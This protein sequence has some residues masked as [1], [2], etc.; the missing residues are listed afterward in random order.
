V[1]EASHG[2]A[3]RAACLPRSFRGGARN[4][5]DVTAQTAVNPKKSHVT[6]RGAIQGSSNNAAADTPVAITMARPSRPT[7]RA[8]RSAVTPNV[9]SIATKIS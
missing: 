8:T 1:R 5:D 6:R 3:G 7:V 9:K 4:A 2:S